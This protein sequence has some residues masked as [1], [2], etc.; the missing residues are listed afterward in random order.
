M[1]VPVIGSFINPGGAG[2]VRAHIQNSLTNAMFY[3]EIR[4][5]LGTFCGEFTVMLQAAT[6]VGIAVYKDFPRVE[7]ADI[8]YYT[9]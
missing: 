8:P 3:K 6:T 2:T 1:L 5:C 9:I 7:P 4:H